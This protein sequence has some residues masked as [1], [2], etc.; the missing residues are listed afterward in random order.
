MDLSKNRSWNAFK[1]EILRETGIVSAKRHLRSL[2][3]DG[4]N[5]AVRLRHYRDTYIF[6]GL[7]YKS[8]VRLP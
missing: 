3:V 6:D 5:L 4:E 8:V 1:K 7:R 2:K